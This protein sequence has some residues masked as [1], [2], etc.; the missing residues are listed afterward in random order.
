MQKRTIF[1]LIAGLAVLFQACKREPLSWDNRVVAPL[2]KTQLGLGQIDTKFLSKNPSDSSFILNYENLVYSYRMANV[3][4]YDTGLTASFNLKKLKLSDQTIVQQITLG[5]I[6]PVFKLLNGQ[7]AEIP[8]QNQ[9]NLAPVDIDAS[10]FFETATLDSGFLDISIAN[11]LP[12]NV[13]LVVFELTNAGDNSQ[14]A[15]DSFSNIPMNGS[16]TKRI[17]LKDKTV[18]KQLKGSIKRLTTEASNGTVLID[19]NKGVDLKLTVSQLRPRYAIAAF[20]SQNV[21]EQDEGLTVFMGGA[22]VKYFKAKAGNLKIH[23]VSTIQEDMTM[24][25]E[26]PSATKNGV[27]LSSVV[28][29]PAAKPG[30]S[31]TRDE[32]FDLTNYLIDFRGK[33]PNVKDTVNTFHQ[34]LI[35]RLDSS[36]RKVAIGLKD[37]IRLDYRMESL[38]PDYAIGYM[39]QSLTQTGDQKAP[40]DLFKGLNGD[41]KFKDFKV[42]L[43]V[44]NG[45][46]ADGRVKINS[47]KGENIFTKNSLAL[48]ATPLNNDILI[49]SPPFVRDAYTESEIVLDAGNSNIKQFMENLPQ[50]LDYNLDMEVNPNGN[51]SLYKDFVFDNSR[52]DIFLKVEA[53]AS[54]SMGEFTLRDTQGIDLKTM[55]DVSRIK[56]A[57]MDVRVRNTFPL[58]A[59]LQMNLLDDQLNYLESLDIDPKDQIIEACEVDA[60]GY[61]LDAVETVF[62]LGLGKEKMA[63]L[64]SAKFIAITTTLVGSGQMQKIYDVSSISVSTVVDFEYEVKMGK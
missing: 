26:I 20:P 11:N 42:S 32:F 44:K 35:V 45:I 10:A 14:V 40:F 9:G 28:K 52:V 37:S 56:S 47:L 58:G 8:E 63:A 23:L 25:F 27:V 4:A 6:N 17:D 15:Y 50:M 51:V 49:T 61:P 30:G 46:G 3:R 55:G 54:F 22:E 33:N 64:K 12:V 21:I 60:K 31:S 43:V 38:I 5:Q 59:K 39:G 18:T 29:L 57:K 62:T 53:P 36:G 34:I 13:K 1:G 19:A 7:T 41:F 24:Y 48:N 16:V 2:F